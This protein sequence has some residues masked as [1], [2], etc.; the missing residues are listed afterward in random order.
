MMRNGLIAL[1]AIALASSASYAPQSDAQ[2]TKSAAPRAISP[3]EKAQGAKYHP[4]LL[5]EYGGAYE[6]T[7][8]TYVTRVGKKISLQS[9]LSNAEGDF[10][11][12]LLN[13]P[14]ENAFAIPGGYVYVTRQLLALMNDEAEL[15]SV[16]GHEVGH[17]AARHS[18][19]RNTTSTIGQIL[20]MGV[21]AL[22]G[23]TALSQLA[24]YGTQLYTL[25]FSRKQEYQA[26]DLGVTYLARGGY[27]P[28]AASSMLAS[29]G[30]ETALQSRLS[31]QAR[32]IP[33]W[34]ST[35]PNSTDR[36][37]RARKQA[38]ATGIPQG[39]G[40]RNR[41]AFLN[42]LDG[43]LYDDD[44][45]EGF[46][47]GQQ[48]LHPV[49]KLKFAAPA[50]YQIVNG[51][52]AVTI[53]GSGAKA[54]FSAGRMPGNGLAGYIDAVFKSIAGNSTINYSEIRNIEINGIHA[55]QA[56]A[57]ANNASGQVDVVVTAYDFG[58][59]AYHF[60][61]IAP[62]GQG[63]GPLASLVN[64]FSRMSDAEAK[65]IKPRVVD[66]VAVKAGDTP[67]S[68]SARMAYSDYRL[69]RFLTLNALDQNSRLTP[70]QKVKLIIY[71]P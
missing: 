45:K 64:S 65:A 36:V 31:G 25:G 68:L 57:R 4:D 26:D 3:S 10:T 29:L 24:G 14:V 33:A 54:Q 53:S 22:T 41:D 69:E 61:T 43:M 34:A 49:L 39:K 28:Y 40:A 19:K 30:A 70:G 11:V 15:A 44:P 67:A 2:S 66:V 50:G 12:T 58:P 47:S 46:V 52:E 7:Q 13:S 42:M 5:A 48:F 23:N 6:G 27:D 18:A 21:G 62:A 37:T 16:M 20:S 32:N 9:G 71:G 35:H 63:T 60:M 17:V 56:S 55:A 1:T 38:S 8:A 59:M 51:T